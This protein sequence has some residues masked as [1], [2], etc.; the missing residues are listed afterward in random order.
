MESTDFIFNN[1]NSRSMGQFLIKMGPG[2]ITSPFFGGQTI[3]ETQVPNK[4]IPYHFGTEKEPLE[5][6][7]EVSPLDE[8]WTPEKRSALAK[9]LIYETYKPF[10]TVDDMNK[11]YYAI[12]T[13]APN[14]EL[15]GGRGF[16]PI[17]FRTNSPYAWTPVQER[18]F[19]ITEPTTITIDNM[20]NINKKFRPVIE[21]T[22]TGATS[23]SADRDITFENISNG[24]KI[25]KFTG[26]ELKEQIGLDNENE[27]ILTG[28]TN[29]KPFTK[30][31]GTWLELVN[32]E[33]KIKVTGKCFLK[34]KMQ[35]PIL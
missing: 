20:S 34:F 25:T 13:A 31:N 28:K 29:S 15:Y 12:V 14:F 35:F 26:L 2:S 7:I 11:L 6:T 23:S 16:I 32:G 33:N 10:Q 21:F 19:V 9:W 17:T 30:F 5:F 22:L 1:I 4:I 3:Q 27:I 24:G 18:S 8:K